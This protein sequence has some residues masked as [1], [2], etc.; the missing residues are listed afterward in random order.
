MLNI[1]FF[2]IP[3]RRGTMGSHK[4]IKRYRL[5]IVLIILLF[6]V[7]ALSFNYAIEVIETQRDH[8]KTTLRERD[9][10]EIWDFLL[11]WNSVTLQDS[12]NLATIIENTIIEKYDLDELEK[13]LDSGDDE[14]LVN[15]LN[16]VVSSYNFSSLIKNN[17]NSVIILEGSDRILVDHMVDLSNT[18]KTTPHNSFTDYEEL[19]INPKSYIT[20]RRQILNQTS[21]NPIMLEVHDYGKVD[22]HMLIDSCTY[23][24][25]KRVYMEEGILGLHNYQFLCPTYITK[26]GDIFGN[27]DTDHGNPINNHK[28]T[29]IVTFNIYDQL[30]K[31]RPEI[32][33][34]D[35][36]DHLDFGFESIE[37][38][39]Y[40]ASI[41][42]FVVFFIIAVIYL[43]N[44]N[45]AIIEYLGE[46]AL[47]NIESE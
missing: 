38:A 16:D 12:E 5:R 10:D 20:A 8:Q 40:F 7:S 30:V 17:R 24:N 44:Y 6:I 13:R 4:K 43:R 31:M 37:L 27:S 29:V 25:L 41:V 15:T 36:Y 21:T 1:F 35:Y 34:N 39:V 11:T 28:F 22:D 32:G 3:E 9:F 45:D 19:S 26:D 33:D 23:E 2:K 14:E 46:E 42:T 47:E 18:D